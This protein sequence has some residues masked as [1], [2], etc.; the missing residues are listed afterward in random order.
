[1]MIDEDDIVIDLN[2][3][4]NKRTKRIKNTVK[5]MNKQKKIADRYGH[6]ATSQP[7]RFAKRHA[8]DCGNPG[9]KICGNPRKIYKE[10]T[11]QERKQEQ[12]NVL[13]EREYSSD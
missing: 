12:D 6:L 4:K 7:H 1:M 13:F 11:I 8:M 9:C 2:P 3:D 5:A 10:K